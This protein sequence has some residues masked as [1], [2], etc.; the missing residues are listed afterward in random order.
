M[1]FRCQAVDY[2][3]NGAHTR[4]GTLLIRFSSEM[5]LCHWDL[6]NRTKYLKAVPE[7]PIKFAVCPFGVTKI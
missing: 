3:S 1:Q 6:M 4:N 7:G 2:V 5:L